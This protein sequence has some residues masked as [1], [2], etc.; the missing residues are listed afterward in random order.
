MKKIKITT[1][2]YLLCSVSVLAQGESDTPQKAT[3]ATKII[4]NSVAGF[5]PIF[6]ANFETKKKYDITVYTIFW[7]NPSFGTLE[8]GSDLLLETA[9]GLGFKLSEY[10]YVNPSFGFTSGRFSSN[11]S[12]TRIAEAAVPSVYVNYQKGVIDFEGYLSYYKSIRQDGGISTRDYLLNWMAP[13]VKVNQR[14]T[15]G[16]FYESFGITSQEEGGNPQLIY[17]WL[18]GSI[19]LKLDANILLRVSMGATLGTDV[20]TS[21]EFYKVSAFIP[22]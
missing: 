3:F 8:S 22:L 9:V 4:H 13:G 15:T 7:T 18:G 21:S 12:E 6:F 10:L 17:R 16:A 1:V 19:K 2:L 20:D 14:V 11:S 5:Y